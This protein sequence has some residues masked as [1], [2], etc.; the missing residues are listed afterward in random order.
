MEAAVGKIGVPFLPI[1]DN[2]ISSCA[3]PM[4]KLD[5]GRAVRLAGAAD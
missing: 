2:P 4:H 3:M 5:F 1:P